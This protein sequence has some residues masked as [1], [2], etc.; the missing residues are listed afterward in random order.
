MN[1]GVALASGEFIMFLNSDDVLFDKNT[2]KL[3][4]T[5]IL[6]YSLDAIYGNISFFKHDF[7]KPER[8]WKSSKFNVLNLKK[9]FHPP[10]PG[11]TVSKKLFSKVGKFNT[12]YKIVSDYDFML[13]LFIQPNIKVRFI[14]AIIVNMRLG[15][16]STTFKGIFYSFFEF[17]YVLKSNNYS[18][19]NILYILI[20][21]YIL[22][23]KQVLFK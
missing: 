3:L 7:Q 22:K 15:G 16:A 17:I 4:M 1:K 9:G 8:I 10:H 13:R 23:I 11:L 18:N 21:R 2:I 6:E 5:N 14:D 19:Y 12:N 20:N